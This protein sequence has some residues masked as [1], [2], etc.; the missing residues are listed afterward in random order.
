MTHDDIRRT[1]KNQGYSPV[2]ASASIA[3]LKR[4]RA[5]DWMLERMKVGIPVPDAPEL[6]I[7]G[8]RPDCPPYFPNAH[9]PTRQ[10]LAASTAKSGK[11]NVGNKQNDCPTD[12]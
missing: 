6:L 4:R 5:P 1:A 2:T 10:G 8:I 3:E 11:E 12:G 9:A 7:L